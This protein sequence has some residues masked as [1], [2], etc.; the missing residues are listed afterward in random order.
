MIEAHKKSNPTRTETVEQAR[1]QDA[2]VDDAYAPLEPDKWF[3]VSKKDK[4]G[5]LISLE[6][7]NNL[8]LDV[9]RQIIEA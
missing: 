6:D 7:S 8:V 4:H 3:K 9:V 2:K 5:E 1:I